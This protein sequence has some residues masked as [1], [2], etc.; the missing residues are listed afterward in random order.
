MSSNWFDSTR[1]RNCKH[2]TRGMRSSCLRSSASLA[3][4]SLS[5]TKESQNCQRHSERSLTATHYASAIAQRLESFRF[6][7]F[8]LCC[9]SR[10]FA[11]FTEHLKIDFSPLPME[12]FNSEWWKKSQKQSEMQA[13]AARDSFF[14]FVSVI[15]ST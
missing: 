1:R 12:L 9:V 11:V 14:R 6:R 10:R 8:A 4:G 2:E 7:L 5:S 3:R 15:Y 13:A